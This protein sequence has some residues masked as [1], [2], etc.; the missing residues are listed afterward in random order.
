MVIT[1]S[2]SLSPGS[3]GGV[4]VAQEGRDSFQQTLK[5]TQSEGTYPVDKDMLLQHSS[6]AQSDQEADPDLRVRGP[7]PSQS[8]GQGPTAG[9][10]TPAL[11]ASLPGQ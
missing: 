10:A 11:G 5:S 1:W 3:F 9:T 2:F 6:E 4:H 7:K 8:A